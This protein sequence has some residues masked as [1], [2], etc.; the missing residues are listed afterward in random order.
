[1]T[2]VHLPM[3]PDSLSRG[4]DDRLEHV[5]THLLVLVSGGDTWLTWSR[6]VSYTSFGLHK[7]RNSRH[8]AVKYI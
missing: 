6:T 8:T 1:M 5:D 2:C 4:L 3:T 7:T